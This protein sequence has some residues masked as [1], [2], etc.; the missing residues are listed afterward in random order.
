MQD[1]VLVARRLNAALFMFRFRCDTVDGFE[2]LFL[3]IYLQK[4]GYFSVF[5]DNDKFFES[6]MFL[7]ICI[8]IY[9]K[10]YLYFKHVILIFF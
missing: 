4:I 7:Y 5:Y 9:N 10:L 6:Y 2:E 1:K 8:S 3:S